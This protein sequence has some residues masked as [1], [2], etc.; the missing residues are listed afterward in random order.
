MFK[1]L[2]NAWHNLFRTP[3][4]VHYP[5]QD[6]LPIPTDYRGL[7]AYDVEHCIFCDRCEKAC[8]PK[9][10]V[11]YQHNNG[12]KEY[13]YNASLCIYCGECVRACPKADEA[14]TH[15]NT[16]PKPALMSEHVNE[17]W[18]VWQAAARE[19]REQYA[20]RKKADKAKKAKKDETSES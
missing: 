13:R 12:E 19:S 1:S 8:P 15:T 6:D 20:A 10:I 2:A 7:I 11:F 4:T 3:L 5:Y 18:F 16:P 14:L 17:E 9:A